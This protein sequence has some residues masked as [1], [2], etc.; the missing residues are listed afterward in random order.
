VACKSAPA[1]QKWPAN[2]HLPCRSGLQIRTCPAEDEVAG[3]PDEVAGLPDEVAGLPDE[4][5]GLPDEVAG[6]PDEVA[7]LPDEV[8]G[9]PDEVAGFKLGWP[10][11][12]RGPAISR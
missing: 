4:V 11:T 7:G 12:G 2:P 6:L 10:V 9:L 1:L 8:A 5:A 3:L